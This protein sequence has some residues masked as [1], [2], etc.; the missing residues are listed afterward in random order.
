MDII[1]SSIIERAMPI[2]AEIDALDLDT[3]VEVV[4]RLRV[5]IH[6]HSPFAE[7]P[8][9]CVVWIRHGDVHANDY[10]PNTVAPPEMRLLET[11]ISEDGYTQPIVA[12]KNGNGYEVVDGFHRNRVGRESK[13]ISNRICGYLPLTVINA[14]R[15][16]RTDRIASTIWT[17]TKF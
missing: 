1:G 11:S 14:G 5:A 12:W 3:K 13:T 9:D 8:V 15:Q 4:N 7:E 16:E 6:K 10:N 17:R 2:L